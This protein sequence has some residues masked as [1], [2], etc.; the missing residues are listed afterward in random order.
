MSATEYVRQFW[1]E[2]EE[3]GIVGHIG[4]S[5]SMLLAELIE[6]HKPRVFVEIGTASGFSAKLFVPK[7][8]CSIILY[9][10]DN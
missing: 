9:L 2:T 7:G 3:T 5:E 6:R 1:D 4:R 10:S 8:I